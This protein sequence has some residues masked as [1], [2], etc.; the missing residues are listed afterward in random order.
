MNYKYKIAGLGEVLWDVHESRKTFG[1]APANCACHCSELGAVAYVISCVGEDELG[2]KGKDFLSS[3]GVN[4][5]GI[6]VSEKF[7]TGIVNVELDSEGKPEYEILENVAWDYIP[8]NGEMAKIAGQLD[9]VCFGTLSQRNDI[10]KKSIEKFLDA[11]SAD[12][13]R[14]FDINIRQNYYSDEVILSS[15]K[16]ASA[17]KINDEELPLLTNLLKITGSEEEQLKALLKMFDLKLA[18][19]TYG[20]KGA[21]MVTKDEASFEIPPKPE[22]VLSTVGAG[23]SFTATAI[24]GFLS[25]NELS[26]INKHANAVASFVCTQMGAVPN[27]PESIIKQ[28]F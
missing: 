6:A 12:C 1:G 2:E 4:I 8:F 28:D 5:D 21:L 7:R 16:R 15:L 3:C 25:K 11:T 17:L 22:K 14:V 9:A 24:I 23:D 10:S 26:K 13:L 20:S 19:L 27:L 18:I